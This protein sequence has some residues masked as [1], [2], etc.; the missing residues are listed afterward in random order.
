MEEFFKIENQVEQLARTQQEA[1]QEAKL[2]AQQQQTEKE[3]AA[4]PSIFDKVFGSVM[5]NLD[6]CESNFDCVRPQ[7]C[8]DYVFAKKCCTSG[9]PILSNTSKQLQ[10]ARIP[11]YGGDNKPFPPQ[12]R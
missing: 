3:A 9:S 10:Y 6:T 2:L 1:I 11:V 8:C 4:G 12:Q 7:V 5:K